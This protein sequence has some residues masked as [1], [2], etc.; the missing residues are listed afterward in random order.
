MGTGWAWE[1]S[2]ALW[3]VGPSK[4]ILFST[5]RSISNKSSS[6][7]PQA[8]WA[9]KLLLKHD[10]CHVSD[11]QDNW[12]T[13]DVKRSGWGACPVP[14]LKA[15]TQAALIS[16]RPGYWPPSWE[17]ETL[18]S[19]FPLEDMWNLWVWAGV[20]YGELQPCSLLD[21]TAHALCQFKSFNLNHQKINHVGYRSYL[22][23]TYI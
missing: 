8:S 1:P 14:Y 20:T 16:R 17:L 3:R 7:V 13:R 18:L 21:C 2:A 23:T 6:A 12:P 4:A 10:P 22:Q 15:D 5:P 19:H 9:V 11:L